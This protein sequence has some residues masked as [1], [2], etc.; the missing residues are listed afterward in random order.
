MIA[1][2]AGTLIA[3]TPQ[4]VIIDVHGV[5]YEVFTSLQT[6]YRLPD[7]K[8]AVRL[9]TYTHVRE[10]ALVLYGFLSTEEKAAF[11]LLI[12]VSGVGPRLGLALL[13]GL[14]V[15][16]LAIAIRSGDAR[17]LSSVPGIGQKTAARLILELQ[18]KITSIVPDSAVE[19]AAAP[20]SVADDALSALVNL[21][22]QA[23]VAK[24]LLKQIERSRPGEDLTV[25]DFLREALRRLSK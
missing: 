2:L 17:R 18:S 7:L 25:E 19:G 8:Q 11:L 9:H 5:G 22:Y 21:G 23:P 12:S 13:S 10:D 1:A 15:A 6:Y 20:S 3:K 24:D 4:S 14:S 16:E